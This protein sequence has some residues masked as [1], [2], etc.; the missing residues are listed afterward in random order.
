MPDPYRAA[1]WRMPAGETR[2]HMDTYLHRLR[3]LGAGDDEVNAAEQ[4][5]RDDPS[6]R[7]LVDTHLRHLGDNELRSEIIAV[8]AEHEF[9]HTTEAEAVEKAAI[10][11]LAHAE[12]EAAERIGGSVFSL[13]AWVGDDLFRAQAVLEL[14]QEAPS[15]HQRSTL[16]RP[17]SAMLEA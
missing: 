10:A 15:E 12:A 16:V 13:L 2:S 8:Q 14:E 9:H 17:L 11:R 6:Y 3:V 7:D 4:S 1:S 5:Y